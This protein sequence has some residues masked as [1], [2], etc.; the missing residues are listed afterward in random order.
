MEATPIVAHFVAGALAG[1]AQSLIMDLWEINMYSWN[2]NRKQSFY[3]TLRKGVNLHL[4]YRRL[5]HSAASHSILFGSYEVFRRS[6]LQGSVDFFVSYPTNSFLNALRRC[7]L[8][9]EKAKG[10]YDM[11]VIPIST[12]FLA[13]G[14]AGQAHAAFTHYA[15]HWKMRNHSQRLNFPLGRIPKHPSLRMLARGFIPS[16]LAF[17]VFEHG[18]DLMMRYMDVDDYLATAVSDIG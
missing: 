15:S 4:V 2:H 17:T 11:T 10:V 16:A 13:G 12:T 7:G 8:V 14:F 1:I 9:T 3:D 18:A 6:L 5:L